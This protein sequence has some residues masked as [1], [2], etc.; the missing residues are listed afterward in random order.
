MEDVPRLVE[1][2]KNS[3]QI[4]FTKSCFLLCESGAGARQMVDLLDGALEHPFKTTGQKVRPLACSRL[5]Q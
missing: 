3:H 4:L 2:S 1:L 5:E